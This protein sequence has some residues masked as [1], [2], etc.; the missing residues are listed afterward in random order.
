MWFSVTRQGN[1]G[2]GEDEGEGVELF[3]E[4]VERDYRPIPELDVYDTR[5]LDDE[6]YEALSPSARAEVDRW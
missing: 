3:G 1:I 5:M 4:N 2:D 6:E